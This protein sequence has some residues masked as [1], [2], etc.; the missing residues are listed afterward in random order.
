[1]N[2]NINFDYIEGNRDPQYGGII[3]DICKLPVGATFFVRNGCWTGTICEDEKGLY[4]QIG[5]CNPKRFKREDRYLL[6][7][8]PLEESREEETKKMQSEVVIK[9]VVNPCSICKNKDTEACKQCEINK[10]NI[11]PNNFLADIS[12]ITPFFVDSY[13]EILNKYNQLLNK[14]GLETRIEPFDLGD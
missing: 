3:T 14:I 6:S 10:E 1:M 8:N 9:D 5:G 12:K 13:Y 2:Y 11:I 4:V 7:I